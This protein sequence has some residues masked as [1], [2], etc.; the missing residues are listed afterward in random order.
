MQARLPGSTRWTRE[1][2]WAQQRWAVATS[3]RTPQEVRSRG[4]ASPDSGIAAVPQT[5]AAAPRDACNHVMTLTE[6]ACASARSAS[7]RTAD[8]LQSHQFV[9]SCTGTPRCTVS[10]LMRTTLSIALLSIA[11]AAGG[12]KKKQD[13]TGA[14]GD[15]VKKTAENVN[16]QV[17]DYNK[18]AQDKDSKPDDLEQGPG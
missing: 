16:D 15:E 1:P 9:R 14:A 4:G 18:T 8:T 12:C 13:D 11:I 5:Q 17:K 6:T 2:A 7:I 10:K 3:S